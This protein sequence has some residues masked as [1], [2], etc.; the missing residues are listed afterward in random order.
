MY[1]GKDPGKVLPIFFTDDS[2]PPPH[3]LEYQKRFDPTPL[4]KSCKRPYPFGFK[5]PI[6]LYSVV[7]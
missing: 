3:P 4:K 6:L 7:F 5:F 2:A 1:E